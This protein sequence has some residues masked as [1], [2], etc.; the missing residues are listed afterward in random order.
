MHKVY[1]VDLILLFTDWI[2][3]DLGS[4]RGPRSNQYRQNEFESGA[5]KVRRESGEAPKRR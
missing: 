4:E 5:P 3:F 2:G 1:E